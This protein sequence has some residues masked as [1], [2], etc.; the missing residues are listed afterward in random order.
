[1]SERKTQAYSAVAA[2][3]TAVYTGGVLSHPVRYQGI[4]SQCSAVCA[5]WERYCST[6]GDWKRMERWLKVASRASPREPT[7]TLVGIISP[8]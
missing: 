8:S 4:D 2:N 6:Y 7:Q 5:E 3:E 1:M